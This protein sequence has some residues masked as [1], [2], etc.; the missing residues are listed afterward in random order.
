M[1]RDCRHRAPQQPTAA[2]GPV[3]AGVGVSAPTTPAVWTYGD[4]D[5]ALRS[6]RKALNRLLRDPD[7]LARL[8]AGGALSTA[9]A[10]AALLDT[11]ESAEN[12]A[13]IRALNHPTSGGDRP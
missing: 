10:A 4:V 1:A 3:P 6:C 7:Y 12:T 8:G 11:I 13:R 9:L 2:R 5:D